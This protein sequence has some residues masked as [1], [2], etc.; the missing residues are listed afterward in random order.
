MSAKPNSALVQSALQAAQWSMNNNYG[1]GVAPTTV[2][3]VPNRVLPLPAKLLWP[4]NFETNG[5]AYVFQPKTGYFLDVTTDFYYCPKSKLYYSGKDGV[6]Y[7]FDSTI[8]PPFRRF[9]PPLPTE[10]EVVTVSESSET[11]STI[12]ANSAS[13]P[14]VSLSIGFNKAK[15]KPS[16]TAGKK[17]LLDIAKWGAIQKEEADAEEENKEEEVSKQGKVNATTSSS[18]NEP[19]P[20]TIDAPRSSSPVTTTKPSTDASATITPSTAPSAASTSFVCLLCRRQ[21]NSADM[22]SR[23]EK[24]SK[25][26]AENLLKQKQTQS[27]TQYRD[28]AEERREMFGSVPDHVRKIDMNSKPIVLSTSTVVETSSSVAVSV[29]QDTSNPGNQMLRKMG[30]TEGQGLGKDG[31]GKEQAVGVELASNKGS[32]SMHNT[33]K[34][35]IGDK[36]KAGLEASGY[37]ESILAVTRARYDQLQPPNN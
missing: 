6:Y 12:A 1:G 13:R 2:G 3:N 18:S 17:A 35:T 9:E 33:L 14:L 5:A 15:G 37:K 21:F 11:T 22:L 31:Q 8:D 4:P 16:N 20:S 24:E 19:A 36:A 26:H 25:L 27:S 29:T 30:W 23:H 32:T 10:P 28:R 7:H 34:G